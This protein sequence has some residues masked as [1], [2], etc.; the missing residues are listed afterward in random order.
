[1]PDRV[2]QTKSVYKEV[3]EPSFG[4]VWPAAGASESVPNPFHQ[5]QS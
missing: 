3:R 4:F 2:V 5:I 1:M